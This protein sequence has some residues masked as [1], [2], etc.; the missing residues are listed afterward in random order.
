MSENPID[1]ASDSPYDNPYQKE[2]LRKHGMGW[3]KNLSYLMDEQFRLPGTRFRFG[4]DPLLNLIPVVGDMSGF[5]VSGGLLLA[6]AKKGASNRLVV[7]MCIN[8]FLD[9]TIGAIPILGQIFDFFYKSNTRNL[10][11]MSEYYLEGKHQG[12]G[13]NVLLLVGII[14]LILFILLIYVLWQV[15]AWL[16]GLF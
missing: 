6:M 16:F 13:K 11:L 3:I 2:A 9:A 15:G 12:S 10:R 14:L 5:L 1:S 4:V 8:I 7:L